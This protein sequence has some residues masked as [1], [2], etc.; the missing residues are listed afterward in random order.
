MDEHFP[1]IL[2]TEGKDTITVRKKKA[3]KSGHINSASN[4]MNGQVKEGSCLPQSTRPWSIIGSHYACYNLHWWDYLTSI[5]HSNKEEKENKTLSLNTAK[6]ENCKLDL[7]SS[8]ILQMEKKNENQE[9]R[10][11]EWSKLKQTDIL[12]KIHL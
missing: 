1:Q 8:G 5:L 12:S 3:H 6:A 7:L 10:L 9:A 4:K 2:E 11:D